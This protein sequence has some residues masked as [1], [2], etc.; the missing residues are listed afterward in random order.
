MKKFISR[1]IAVLALVALMAGAASWWALRQ[2]K[3]VP[4]FY[5]EIGEMQKPMLRRASRNV[6]SE[7]RRLQK[8]AA[9]VGTWQADFSVDEINA[10]LIQE[11]PRKFPRLLAQGASDPR[12]AIRDG[13]L[14]AAVRYQH[15]HFDTVVSCRLSVEL[16]EQPNILA[17]KVSDLRAG[18]LPIPLTK[19]VNGISRE[20]ARGG[21]D[22]RWD[23]TGDDPVALVVVPQE[24]PKY[25]VSPVIVESV[26]LDEERLSLAGHSGPAAAK[27]YQ[28]RGPV[29]RF[30]SYQPRNKRSWYRPSPRSTLR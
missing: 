5:A 13:Q 14:L 2:T 12:I 22:I 8:D 4:E 30:V 25:V 6:E 19:F 10:W 16:T 29:H 3:Q 11:L 23:H 1:C 28:P 15:R 17:L 26:T 20:A 9:R 21:L 24:H 27:C 7:V 18:A